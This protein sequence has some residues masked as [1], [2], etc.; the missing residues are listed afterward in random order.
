HQNNSLDVCFFCQ[1]S[2]EGLDGRPEKFLCCFSCGFKAHPTCMGYCSDL[3]SR[4]RLYDWQ[5]SD[6][7]LCCLCSSAENPESLL[8]C[9]ECDRGYH[10]YCHKPPVN[11]KPV[12][13][14]SCKDCSSLQTKPKISP[15]S[16]IEV[17]KRSILIQNTV[18][19]VGCSSGENSNQA[20][21]TPNS[22]CHNQVNHQ[23]SSTQNLSLPFIDDNPLIKQAAKEA[24]GWNVEQVFN[25]ISQLGFADQ[26]IAFR[27]EEIDG[28]ALLLLK[29]SDVLS[30]L[31][32]KLGPALKIHRRLS[33]LQSLVLGVGEPNDH[34]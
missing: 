9:D 33:I 6:C 24:H 4:C 5:C 30:M 29:R 2:Q 14:W 13:K 27:R 16:E 32:L 8:L 10:T 21:F 34:N 28:Q 11:E 15:K 12:G 7:K 18:E 20:A 1:S 3:A 31:S 26:A 25:F 19:S 22:H 23:Q 17:T